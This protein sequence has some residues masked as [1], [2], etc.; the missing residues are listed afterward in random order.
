MENKHKIAIGVIVAL[1]I[2]VIGSYAYFESQ[3]IM[4]EKKDAM[5]EQERKAQEVFEKEHFNLYKE[6]DGGYINGTI[7]LTSG[8]G[9]I[10]VTVTEPDQF[11]G[12]SSSSSSSSSTSSYSSSNSHSSTE[13]ELDHETYTTSINN[14]NFN[15]KCG[16]SEIYTNTYKSNYSS[17]SSSSNNKYHSYHNVTGYV[18]FDGNV[19]INPGN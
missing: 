17:G 11:I 15:L 5:A 4:N 9:K 19:I 8:N 13:I 1:I 16:Y 12:S 18:D 3:K 7:N 6:I 14:Y 2:V 10:T